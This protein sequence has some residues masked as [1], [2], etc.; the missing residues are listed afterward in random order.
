MEGPTII[1]YVA[2]MVVLVAI[3]KLFLGSKEKR[4]KKV[5]DKKEHSPESD[6]KDV[7]QKLSFK[8]GDDVICVGDK[9]EKEIRCKFLAYSRQSKASV[10]YPNGVIY[11]RALSSLRPAS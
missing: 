4:K 6:T 5:K 2:L 10:R 7:V 3:C 11:K 8:K 1:D 9:G